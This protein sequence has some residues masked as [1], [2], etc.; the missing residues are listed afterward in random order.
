[1]KIGET[2]DF[3][4]PDTH[5]MEMTLRKKRRGEKEKLEHNNTV[6]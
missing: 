2:G 1:V 6:G 4:S 3:L 5:K